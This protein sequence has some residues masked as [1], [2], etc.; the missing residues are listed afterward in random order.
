MDCHIFHYSVPLDELVVDDLRSPFGETGDLETIAYFY[1]YIW[2]RYRLRYVWSVR[3][4]SD[5]LELL[6]G[7]S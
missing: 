7:D 6:L 4:L 3:L 5:G 2:H 1:S